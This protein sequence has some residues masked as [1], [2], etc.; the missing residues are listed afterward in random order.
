MTEQQLLDLLDKYAPAIRDAILAGI[1]DVRD[2]ARLTEIITMIEQNNVDGALRALG[3]NPAVFSQY[4]TLMMQAFEQ[5]GI[6]MMSMQPKYTP[7]ATGVMTMNRFN[8]RDKDAERW[9]AERS[10]ALVTNIEE[11]VRLAVRD[12]LADGLERGVNPRTTA[13]DLVG[14]YNRET[15]HREGGI[16]GLGE[17]EQQ[18]SRSVRQKLLTLDPSYFEMD[19]RDKRFDSI[20]R[21]AISTGRPL[22]GDQVTK[23]VDRYRDRAL[24]HRG[25]T[26]GRSETLAALNRSEYESTR[27]ALAQSNLPLT[28][29]TK[30]WD[31]AGDGR[32]RHTHAEMDGQRVGIDEPFISP[33]GAQ[34]MHPHDASLGAPAQERVACRCRVKYDIDYLWKYRNGDE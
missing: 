19:L 27:Q 18:W 12:A 24:R 10:S 28:A 2:N 22:T 20:V 32:V 7:D 14:R 34:M 26:I 21:E 1:R 13:L 30:V 6:L 31:S 33:S 3:Y 8:V 4:Y 25:E 17:R 29:A 5:G 9:L 11:D 23:L 15:G 16:V